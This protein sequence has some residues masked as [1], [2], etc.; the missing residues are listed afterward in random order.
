MHAGWRHLDQERDQRVLLPHLSLLASGHPKNSQI[1]SYS[2][3]F[4]GRSP[5][6]IA[7]YSRRVIPSCH[8]AS[9]TLGIVDR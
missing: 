3:A 9:P 5:S 6:S 4:G 7:T 2:S 8:P 1:A